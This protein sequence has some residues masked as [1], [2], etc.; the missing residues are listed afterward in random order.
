M[1]VE[2]MIPL[3]ITGETVYI[4][5]TKIEAYANR[6]SFV[7]K[8][9]IT[10]YEANMYAKWQDLLEEINTTY[11]QIFTST[12]ET[13]LEDLKG[14]LAFLE[15]IMFISRRKS[16]RPISSPKIMNA[17]KKL[18][19]KRISDIRKIWLTTKAQILTPVPTTGSYMSSGVTHEFYRQAMNLKWNC[20]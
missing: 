11:C 1:D 8:K 13:F 9:A 5:G 20:L 14:V 12:C 2:E 17:R 16:R 3:A 4:D 19:L 7:W 6:Y 10:K 18:L 15:K